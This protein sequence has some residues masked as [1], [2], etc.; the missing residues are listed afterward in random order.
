MPPPPSPL[1]PSSAPHS[2]SPLMSP[3]VGQEGQ[4]SKKRYLTGEA[5]DNP[6]DQ[7]VSKP[8]VSDGELETQAVGND[9]APDGKQNGNPSKKR[10][11]TLAEKEEKEKE[12]ARREQEKVE[13]E[14]E[15]A[16]KKA[17]LEEKKK[18]LEEVKK[19]K[20]EEKR[21]KDEEK[22][23]AQ[24]KKDE[25]KRKKDEE[26]A[27]KDEEK[28]KKERAQTRLSAFFAKPKGESSLP[29]SSKLQPTAPTPDK[30]LENDDRG[31]MATVNVT[32][33]SDYER[34]F[35]PFF[36]KQH[37]TVAPQ[38]S[39]TRDAKYKEYIQRQLDEILAIAK[40]PTVDLMNVDHTITGN[41]VVPT[42]G[43]N[44]DEIADLLHIPHNKRVRRG[45]APGYT[46]KQLLQLM[47]TSEAKSN[48]SP[49]Q[50]VE[51]K[52]PNYYLALLNAL[53]RKHLHFAEDV[54][55]PYSGTFTRA[56]PINSGLRKGRNPFERSLPNVDY[57]YDSEA[58]WIAPEE[59][60]DGEDL[61]SEFGE[62]EDE[63]GEDEEEMDEFLDDE[64]DAVR[65]RAGALCPLL[66]FSSGLCLEDDQGRNERKEFQ[67][68]KL[69]VLIEGVSVPIDPF[70]NHYWLP[71]P[72][73]TNSTSAASSS[74]GNPMMSTF[75]SSTHSLATTSLP[76]RLAVNI[77]TPHTPKKLIPADGL[78]AFKKAVDGSDMTKAG[79]VELLKKQFPKASKD[80]IRET[81][82]KV[83]VRIG[84]KEADK[85]WVLRD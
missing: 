26:K 9:V 15:K 59:E 29:S 69:G 49:S 14:K 30:S 85:R 36:V 75:L 62:E 51:S 2:S 80:A 20:D 6:Q 18:A 16:E 77:I 34:Y 37:V 3:Q 83:A 38:N 50:L 43:I 63:D 23:E 32:N 5:E 84:E 46:V 73:S 1:R 41:M 39:F 48:L 35:Q 65:G 45:K 57:D 71:P 21:K 78:E 74:T 10:K 31:P 47:N 44:A 64:D 56:P 82:G 12:K 61:L 11:L 76:H 60:E 40:N 72:K 7:G 53:P 66:P 8:A 19:R 55:P 13:K 24:R 67:E 52:S 42:R 28:A 25:E 27:K 70:S 4:T 22:A 17:A 79:L 33:P 54:R 81:L 58:E 68:M